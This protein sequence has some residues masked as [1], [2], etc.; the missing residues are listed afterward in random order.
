MKHRIKLDGG[1]YYPQ[2]QKKFLCFSWWVYFVLGGHDG[3]WGFHNKE[4]A[5]SFIQKE[6]E[7]PLNKIIEV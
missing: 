5:E 4:A 3:V 6:K 1:L 7:I 2:Y